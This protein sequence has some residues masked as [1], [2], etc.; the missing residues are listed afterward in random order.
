ML[1][2]FVE[3]TQFESYEDFKANYRVT[4]PEDFNFATHVVDAWAKAEP[5]KRALEWCDDHGH[6]LT[7]TFGEVSLL[8]RRAAAW[9]LSQ[10]VRRGD[11]VMCLLKRRWE[12][13]ITA[14]ALHRI[15]AVVIPASY[16]LTAK[17]IAYRIDAAEIRFLIA[18]NDDWITVQC[19]EALKKCAGKPLGKALVN[20]PRKGWLDYSAA[21]E[22]GPAGF[23]A[24]PDRKSVV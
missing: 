8:S 16:Q 12:Y 19:E 4:C 21:L 20:G 10:G 6:S 7:L 14:V 2:R 9:L 13:W 18:L 24:D 1:E 15:G 3:R 5:E 11:R 17:D 22:E 23:V